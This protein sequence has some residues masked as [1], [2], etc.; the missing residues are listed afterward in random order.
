MPQGRGYDI[1]GLIGPLEALAATVER[2]RRLLEGSSQAEARGVL[3][4][5]HELA[6][7]KLKE[8]L[9]RASRPVSPVEGSPALMET[10]EGPP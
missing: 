9:L 4:R 5:A 1:A 10:G 7:A 3:S 8:A 2:R 6:L